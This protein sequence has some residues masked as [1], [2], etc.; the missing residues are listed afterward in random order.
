[1]KFKPLRIVFEPFDDFMDQAEKKLSK[2]VRSGKPQRRR[3]NQLRF[4]S[5]VA[6]Q[7][8]MSEQK[9]AILAAI[10]SHS[11]RSIYQLA[12]ILERTTQKVIR[13][14]RV[15]EGHGFITSEEI[16]DGRKTK[17]PR[18]AFDY[19]AIVICMPSITYKIEFEDDAA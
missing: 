18:L 14:C 8:V 7:Q 2:A 12:K 16:G 4:E 6:Y 15:L 1:M 13:D 10:Y 3:Q 11:P 5:V 17:L 19:N 9:Y